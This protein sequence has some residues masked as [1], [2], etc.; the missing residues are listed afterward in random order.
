MRGGYLY[1]YNE[2]NFSL[3]NRAE[4][5]LFDGSIISQVKENRHCRI[6]NIYIWHNPT[7][8][9]SEVEQ[10]ERHS[11]IER[12]STGNHIIFL[13][14]EVLVL[15]EVPHL[16]TGKILAIIRIMFKFLFLLNGDRKQGILQIFL[17]YEIH[18]C[19]LSATTA[20]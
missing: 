13:E 9:F 15:S 16:L 19:S 10:Q 6:K 2:Y 12:F 3:F 18:R 5:Y 20:S 4:L 1:E 17:E 14:E 7:Y 8:Q 11:K